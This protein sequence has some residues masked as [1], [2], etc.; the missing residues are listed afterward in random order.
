M[1]RREE[2][3]TKSRENRGQPRCGASQRR[4]VPSDTEKEEGAEVIIGSRIK[5][6][7]PY[8]HTLSRVYF[9]L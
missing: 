9:A 6:I 7:C 5:V 3:E 4:R 1:Q 8:T 2:G